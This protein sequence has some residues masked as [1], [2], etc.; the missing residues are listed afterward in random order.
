MQIFL[1]TARTFTL[2]RFFAMSRKRVYWNPNGCHGL[3]LAWPTLLSHHVVQQTIGCEVARLGRAP[4][5]PGPHLSCTA[6][7]WP[8]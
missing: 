7:L 1:S 2:Q 6:T 8:D 4:P 5:F 3:R